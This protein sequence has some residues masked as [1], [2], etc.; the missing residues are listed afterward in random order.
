MR[1][2]VLFIIAISVPVA[3]AFAQAPSAQGQAQVT[4]S[5]KSDTS[6]PLTSITPNKPSLAALSFP[7]EH[8]VKLNPKRRRPAGPAA[9][10]PADHHVVHPGHPDPGGRP[11]HHPTEPRA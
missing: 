1:R 4:A 8:I 2:A 7:R 3:T 10:A 6:P 9:L 5:T 11:P